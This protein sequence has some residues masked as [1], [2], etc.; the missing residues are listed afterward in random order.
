MLT[1]E[2]KELE[3]SE[4]LKKKVDMICKF[5]CVKYEFIPG[6]IKSIKNT[7]IAYVKPH[8]LKQVREPIDDEN[9]NTLG[10]VIKEV[11]TEVLNTLP[12]KTE[13]IERVQEGFRQVT[14]SPGGTAYSYFGGA[15][16]KPAGKTGTA[17]AFYDGPKWKKG[18]IQPETYNITFVT[19]AP[20][21]NP[22]IAMSIVVP[23]AYQ[24]SSGS[25]K[26]NLE[27]AKEVYEKYFDLKEERA[28]K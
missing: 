10:P 3:I 25:H 28:K 6:N 15:D 9:S 2:T 1:I 8:I 17:E 27:I 20:A 14:Q 26:M 4:N 22:E 13:W 24:S 12:M 18:T 11:K 21:E 7:N 5:A 23:W 16:Y 19:Y